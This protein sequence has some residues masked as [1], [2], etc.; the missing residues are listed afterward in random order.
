MNPT[1]IGELMTRD[2]DLR[3]LIRKRKP[4]FVESVTRDPQH[5][6]WQV[7][8]DYRAGLPIA[9]ADR[10]LLMLAL[11]SRTEDG[12]RTPATSARA[13]SERAATGGAT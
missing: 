10:E 7:L 4:A 8:R 13:A 5:R 2:D 6:C 1:R 12:W 3:K 9:E 11:R